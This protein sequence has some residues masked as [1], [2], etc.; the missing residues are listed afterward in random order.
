MPG[1]ELND[2]IPVKRISNITH[3]LINSRHPAV[4]VFDKVATR[5]QAIA[6]MLVEQLTNPRHTSASER[7]FRIPEGELV[8]GKPGATFIM[9][10]FI[11]T[12]EGGGRFHTE[13]LGAWYASLSIETALREMAHHQYI[14]LKKSHM[15]INGTIIQLRELVARV[16]ADFHD[17]CDLERTRPELYDAN[18]YSHSQSLANGL[19]SANSNGICYKSVR[20]MGGENL[21]V[22]KPPLLPPIQQG[23]HYQYE[24][25][26]DS[27]PVISKL[28]NIS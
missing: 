26:K 4:G 14:R 15:D 20:H 7:F 6:A 22:F 27:E 23:D 25:C 1:A 5:D 3:R 12:G 21:V 11:H 28:T 19:R 10:A 18:D 24:W 9:G 8:L 13:E 16:N 17:L 2:N